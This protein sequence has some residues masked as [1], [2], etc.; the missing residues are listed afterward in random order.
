M[1]LSYLIYNMGNTDF[2][3]T[4]IICVFVWW[5]W[6]WEGDIIVLRF[7]VF[8]FQLFQIYPFSE[9]FYFFILVN[10]WIWFILKILISK[11]GRSLVWPSTYDHYYHW[12]YF[13]DVRTVLLSKLILTVHWGVFLLRCS[14]NPD[15]ILMSRR[16]SCVVYRYSYILH[17]LYGT[18]DSCAF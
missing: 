1:E 4:S 13:I 10:N 15:V 5:G 17:G 7:Y 14:E 9:H 11:I 8:T 12:E 18:T 6:G 2:C 3:I 16:V